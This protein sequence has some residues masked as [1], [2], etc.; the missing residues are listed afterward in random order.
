MV[1]FSA[2]PSWWLVTLVLLCDGFEFPAQS[3]ANASRWEAEIQAFEASDRT[4]PPPQN[5][6]LFIGSSSFRLWQSLAQDFPGKQVINRGF[7][8]S[9]ITDSTALADRIIFP[10]HPRMI[11]LYA[12]DNDLAN[13]KSVQQVVSDYRTF[14]KTVRTRLPE[15]QIAFVSIK[16]SPSRWHL[17]AQIEAANQEIEAI[18]QKGLVFIDVYHPMLGPDGNPDPS[19]FMPDKLHPNTKAYHLWATVIAPYL[20]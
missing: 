6:I 10:Y 18:K 4:K 19:F 7:G 3:L 12:G 14:V 13:G 2:K 16:P 5:A 8:G 1:R 20:D 11:V 17:K 15:A 9:E